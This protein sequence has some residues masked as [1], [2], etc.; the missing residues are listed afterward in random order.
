MEL[1]LVCSRL[2][3]VAALDRWRQVQ[4]AVRDQLVSY[5]CPLWTC[6]GRASRGAA[7]PETTVCAQNPLWEGKMVTPL[8]I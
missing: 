5:D 1:A 8:A 6:W 4:A 7:E 3:G 2:W